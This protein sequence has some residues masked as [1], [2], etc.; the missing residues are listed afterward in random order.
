MINH[1]TFNSKL[2][3]NKV[4]IFHT[5][6]NSNKS[7]SS[8]F[9]HFLASL[10]LLSPIS[11]QL[12]RTVKNDM[13][14]SVSYCNHYWCSSQ[15]GAV[16]QPHLHYGSDANEGDL[17]GSTACCRI[18]WGSSLLQTPYNRVSHWREKRTVWLFIVEAGESIVRAVSAPAFFGLPLIF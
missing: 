4:E 3:F 13:K 7:W 15:G 5:T 14:T 6:P 11:P 1:K 18:F 9:A 17:P 8:T 16:Q 12:P 10:I 2:K